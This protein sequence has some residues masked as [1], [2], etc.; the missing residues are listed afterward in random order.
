M[1]I[2]FKLSTILANFK[3]SGENSFVLLPDY[4]TN[5]IIMLFQAGSAARTNLSKSGIFVEKEGRFNIHE[6]KTA[7]NMCVDSSEYCFVFIAIISDRN[8]EMT[9]PFRAMSTKT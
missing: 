8:K 3:K 4:L 1:L 7:Q 9:S 2:S 5:Y 6:E